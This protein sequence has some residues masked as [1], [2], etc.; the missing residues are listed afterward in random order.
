MKRTVTIRLLPDKDSEAKLRA[1]CSL[2]SKL[3]NEV[4]YARRRMFFETK[5]VDLK[6]TYKEF[7]EKYKT[8]I[9]SATAQQVLNKNDEAW[10]SFFLLLKAKKEGRLPPFMNKVNLP[11]YRKRGGRRVLWTVLRNDQ[12]KID[13]DYIVVR[14]LGA[15]GSLRIRY[16][17]R[18]HVCGKQGRA[19]IHYDSDE[20]KW[21]IHVSFDVEEKIV[22]D[23]RVRVPM[24]LLGDKIAGVD[25]GINN[26]LA[27][28]VD[29]GS[30]MLVSGRSLKSMSFYWRNR[31]ARYQSTLNKYG[32]RTSRKL[33]RMYK[34]WRRQIK[35]Y[36]DWSVRNAVEWMYHKGVKR[37]VVGYPKYIAQN[38]NKN[39]KTNFE[40]VHVWS[41]GYLL[42][43]LRDVAEE[44]GIEVEYVDERNTSRTCPM[45]R[46]HIGH[47][48][49]VRG[50]LNCYKHNKV[51]N[52]D[53]V[54][55]F[56]ILSKTKSIAPSPALS[57]VGVTR[58]RPG[59]GLNP[60]F[61]GNVAPNLPAPKGTLAL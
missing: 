53:L 38:S 11:S 22:R 55:A 24:K 5:S 6:G 39:S 3:W 2:S 45:C 31:I 56:N 12:Y 57:G 60:A 26:L 46:T 27:I 28:Y 42:R 14:G 15:I 37:I 4:S 36:I 7:Y 17:G 52:A 8:L 20:E 33:R 44:Y 61:A 18:I 49:I 48:R 29:D 30:A 54:G 59:A 1:L 34:K 16:S 32:L 58:L 51:F 9:G 41:Y 25:I 43:R 23:K 40:V 50:L 47:K 21:Y 35:S 13:G 10:R 19:E